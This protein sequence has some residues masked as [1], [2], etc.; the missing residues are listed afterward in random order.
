MV[1]VKQN[2][3]VTAAVDVSYICYELYNTKMGWR[4]N[5][6]KNC[7]IEAWIVCLD[8]HKVLGLTWLYCVP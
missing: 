1:Q 3:P 5:L 8:N 6:R 2:N 4:E 7:Q